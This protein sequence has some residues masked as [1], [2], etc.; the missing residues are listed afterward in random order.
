MYNDQTRCTLVFRRTVNIDINGSLRVERAT[1]MTAISLDINK[2]MD[3][4]I[5]FDCVN[6]HLTILN[7]S[8]VETWP[9]L[10]AK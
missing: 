7:R 10:H 4:N 5:T 8:E 9:C 3:D 2:K 1:E 6:I